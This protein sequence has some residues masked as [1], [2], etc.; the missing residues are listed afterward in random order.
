M[1]TNNDYSDIDNVLD[2][3]DELFKRIADLTKSELARI[4]NGESNAKSGMLYMN[5][6]GETKTLVLQSRNLLKSQ[7]RF[8][9]QTG[10]NMRRPVSRV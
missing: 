6:L 3:R 4:S 9:E 1:V 7:R 5:I 10:R 8:M 2:M